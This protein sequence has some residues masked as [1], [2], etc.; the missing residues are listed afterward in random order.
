MAAPA[1]IMGHECGVLRFED[2]CI[3][4]YLQNLCFD[5]DF[6]LKNVS[7]ELIA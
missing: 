7:M 1:H 3:G 2:F 5:V 4:S 6:N